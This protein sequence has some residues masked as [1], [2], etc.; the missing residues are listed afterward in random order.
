MKKTLFITI[1]TVFFMFSCN[2]EDILNEPDEIS[3]TTEISFDTTVVYSYEEFINVLK[4]MGK[5]DEE[6]KKELPLMQRTFSEEIAKN[7]IDTRTAS[8][9]RGYTTNQVQQKNV[10][11]VIEGFSPV[12][13]LKTYQ[14]YRGDW[15]YVAVRIKKQSN[16]LYGIAPSP[17]CG[18]TKLDFLTSKRGYNCGLQSQDFLM[19]TYVI[20][21]YYNLTESHS[22]AEVWYPCKPEQ[23]V[24]NYNVLE[25]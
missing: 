6:I 5:T 8:L 2:E 22:I 23:L 7:A 11:F 24:W 20:K 9:Y 17:E 25:L 16:V 1:L 12:A 4:S 10:E 3:S 18:L 13:S 21:F 15:Y 14:R 19:W